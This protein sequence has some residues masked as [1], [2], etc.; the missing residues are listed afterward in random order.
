MAD[1]ATPAQSVPS[2]E[3]MALLRLAT[4][5]SI[6]GAIEYQLFS[7]EDHTNAEAF[8]ALM[9]SLRR[10]PELTAS[11]LCMV[12]GEM[13]H[14]IVIGYDLDPVEFIKGLRMAASKTVN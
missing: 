3:D 6:I 8:A 14:T 2:P 1:E 4:V 13:A 11:A 12:L 10:A 7:Q 9:S 5:A